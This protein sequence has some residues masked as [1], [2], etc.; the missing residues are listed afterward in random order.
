MGAH[1]H[2]QIRSTE[3][4]Y[5]DGTKKSDTMGT[6]RAMFEQTGDTEMA[7]FYEADSTS[8]YTLQL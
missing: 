1:I 6:R 4:I 5:G 8:T 2:V 7:P 3:H